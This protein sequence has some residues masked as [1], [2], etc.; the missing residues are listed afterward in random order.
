MDVPFRVVHYINQFFGG[1]GGEDKACV[2]PQAKD[3]PVG[4]GLAL[5]ASLKDRGKIVATVICGDDYFAE[6]LE[7]AGQEV[8]RLIAGYRPDVVIA[9]PAFNAGRYGVACG[10]ICRIV[11]SELHIPAVTGMYEENPGAELYKSTV[12]V[13]K[14]ADSVKGMAEAVSSMVRIACKL[15][16]REPIGKPAQEGYMPRGFLKSES[17][18]KTAAQR[19][20]DMLLAKLSGQPFTSEVPLPKF[21]RVAPPPPVHDL[22]EATIALVTDGGLV[23]KG[24]PDRIQGSKATRFGSYSLK[25]LDD[26][27]AKDYEV[28]HIGY[29]TIFISQNPNR[30]VPLDV[31]RELE[32]EGV[33]GKLHDK[34]YSTAGVG[35]TL[36]SSKKI[37]TAIAQQLRNEGVTAVLL[38][39]T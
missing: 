5:Q 23:P 28:I 11:Q 16:A 21:D 26:L 6:R 14:T 3:G 20:V 33:V 25:G 4:P 18:D 22:S 31:M 37:G 36:E 7:E 1:V 27:D 32:N 15:A 19:G 30:L 9:G 35:T 2:G 34:Y 10:E 12:W 8:V 38:T 29:D 17:S 24:N 39:S 13:V